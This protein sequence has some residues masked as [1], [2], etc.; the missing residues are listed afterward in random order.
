MTTRTGSIHQVID[1]ATSGDSI[2]NDALGI[3]AQL[4]GSRCP[5][6]GLWA[7]TAPGGPIGVDMRLHPELPPGSADDVLIAHVRD[8]DSPVWAFVAGRPERIVLRVHGWQLPSTRPLKSVGGRRS[9]GTTDASPGD[10]VQTFPD[11]IGRYGVAPVGF[12]AV[13]PEVAALAD[14][15]RPRPLTAVVPPFFPYDEFAAIGQRTRVDQDRTADEATDP[16]DPADPADATS[17]PADQPRRGD[18]RSPRPDELVG[19]RILCVGRLDPH[20]EVEQL[21][22]AM[23]LAA[24]NGLEAA[25]LIVVGRSNNPGYEVALRELARDLRI[26]VF[27][28]GHCSQPDLLGLMSTATAIVS[29]SRSSGFGVRFVEAMAA[30]VPV[31]AY[32]SGAVPGTVEDA[33]ILLG[34]DDDAE[35]LAEAIVA[36]STDTA[37]RRRLIERGLVRST[38]L[39]PARSAGLLQQFL[40]DLVG[41]IESGVS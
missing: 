32:A 35:V 8:P 26:N 18:R 4:R 7:L 15:V 6:S 30:G 17:D 19:P 34:P 31:V 21:L 23:H 39:T 5:E 14:P 25:L 28:G 24:T 12:L 11:T 29:P 3:Q 41:T 1:L 13:S 10:V 16:A 22:T 38:E 2:T 27:F 20:A 9:A 33:G 40:A 37:L 36:V